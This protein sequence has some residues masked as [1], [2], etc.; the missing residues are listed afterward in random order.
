MQ[1]QPDLRH[2]S[3]VQRGADRLKIVDRR[4]DRYF[5]FPSII[6]NHPISGI[7]LHP[8]LRLLPP[9]LLR[10]RVHKSLSRGVS[11]SHRILRVAASLLTSHRPKR[12]NFSGPALSALPP[13][14]RRQVLRGP[15]PS[16][17][18]R[19]K[20]GLP[21]KKRLASLGARTTLLRCEFLRIAC[22]R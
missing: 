21:D 15:P 6:V 13:T 18:H 5:E 2:I 7:F 8:G 1:V 3:C 9:I 10:F 11:Y 19:E 4:G 17:A 20:V 16:P 12:E 22:R 14:R